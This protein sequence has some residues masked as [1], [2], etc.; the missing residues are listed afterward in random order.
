MRFPIRFPLKQM[1]SPWTSLGVAPGDLQLKPTLNGG[2]SFRWRVTGEGEWTSVLKGR[3]ISLRQDGVESDVQFKSHNRGSVSEA[4]A[5]LHDYFQLGVDLKALYA[6]WNQDVNFKKKAGTFAGIRVLRQD[7]TENVFAFICSSNN[8]ISR[9]T[10]M[11]S[12][13][14]ERYGTLAGTSEDD[15]HAYYNFPTVARLAEAGVEDELRKLGFG[16]R[17]RYIAESARYILANHDESWLESLRGREYTDCKEELMKLSGVGPKVADC[18]CLMSMDQHGAIP[19]DTH[20]WQIAKRDYRISG[21][22][23]AKTVTAKNYLAIGDFFRVLFGTHAGWAHSVLFTADLRQIGPK[24]EPLSVI[25]KNES[26]ELMQENEDGTDHKMLI[27][28]L[29]VTGVKDE[30]A[31]FTENKVVSR[32]VVVKKE[33]VVHETLLGPRRSLRIRTQDLPDSKP[34]KRKKLS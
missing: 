26:V 5:I 19:V 20:V 29:E 24:S 28:K 21:L 27:K 3:I 18:A 30:G 9:I 12:K 16:Y 32:Q 2:Q 31:R 1:H 7:P 17:A 6:R 11:V 15:G 33:E 22:A 23:N 8:N 13:M 14:A 34:V 4:K 10:S 25:T